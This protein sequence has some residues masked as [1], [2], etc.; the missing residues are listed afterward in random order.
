[1]RANEFLPEAPLSGGIFKYQGT[2]KDR[3]PI[4]LD[5]IKKQSPFKV[6]TIDGIEDIVFDPAEYHKVANWLKNRVGPLKIKARDD[7]RLI[8]FG[9]IVKTKEFGGEQAGQREK[10]EQGQIQGLSDELEKAK[11]GK[12]Y[13][14]LKVGNRVVKAASFRKTSELLNGR[15]PKSD[16][17]VYDINDN[18]VAWV[19]LKDKTFRWGG[20]QHLKN[21]PE[22]DSWL[23]KVRKITGGVFAPG[24]AFGLHVSNDITD[25]IVFGKDF[26]T[27]EPGISNVDVVLIGWA[28][29]KK[30]GRSFELS[31]DTVYPNG[32]PPSGPHSP[33]LVLRYMTQRN[34]V[35]FQ[36][37]R[38]E[39]NTT[40]EGRKVKFLD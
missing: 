19:S 12:P 17:T 36:N 20:W 10:I 1:M 23:G 35:G 3:V 13:I 2:P 32:V 21:L 18:P 4:L 38:G 22:I 33:Y 5:K 9:A 27:G 28:K 16:M 6:K 31:S 34:D 14:N 15:Q 39:T 11:N 37:A 40:S 30:S 29:I 7:E 8:P 24:Q 25:R 26:E